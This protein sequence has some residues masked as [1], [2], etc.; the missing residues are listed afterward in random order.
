M[1]ETGTTKQSPV[2]SGDKLLVYMYIKWFIPVVL[3]V[4]FL[5]ISYNFQQNK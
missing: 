1:N 3:I 4:F 2:E 5:Y